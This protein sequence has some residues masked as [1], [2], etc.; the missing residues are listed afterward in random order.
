MPLQETCRLLDLYFSTRGPHVDHLLELLRLTL[1]PQFYTPKG[2]PVQTGVIHYPG[3]SNVDELAT[4]VVTLVYIPDQDTQRVE[5][6]KIGVH[7]GDLW[8]GPGLRGRDKLLNNDCTHAGG[9]GG[10]QTS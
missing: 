1:P 8:R 4:E 6:L 9:P 5:L 2:R 7:L 10:P 3:L